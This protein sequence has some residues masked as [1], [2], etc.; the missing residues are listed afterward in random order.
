MSKKKRTRP[1]DQPIEGFADLEDEL[2]A[3]GTAA[4]EG[5]E[6]S[7]PASSA[8]ATAANQGPAV[9][10][11]RATAPRPASGR[12]ARSLPWGTLYTVSVIGA[13]LGLGGAALL[14]SGGSAGSAWRPG[15]LF[16]IGNYLAPASHPLNLVA[17]LSVVIGVIGVTGG[18]ALKAALRRLEQDRGTDA[19]V[20]A[21]LTAL[22]LD[23]EGP[24]GD[25][26]LRDH[27]A[28]GTFTAEVL[29]AWRLQGARL[30]RLNGVEGEIG[31]LQKALVENTRDVLTGRF[32]SPA[33]GAMADELVRF[34]DARNADAQELAELR[35]RNREDSE[36]I[37]KLIQDARA[38]N[39]AT[40][41][42]IGT[43]G[44]ALERMARR[45]EDLGAAL[46]HGE[47]AGGG[48]AA[49]LLAD[50]RHDLESRGS[51]APATA[52][53][54]LAARGSKL[55]FQI[56]MEVARL[57]P[58]GERLQ[59]MSQALEDLTTSL[60][61]AVDGSA[62]TGAPVDLAAVQGKL[63]AL[64]RQLTPAGGGALSPEALEELGRSGPV[65]GRVAANLADVAR[66]FQA[67][68][69]RLVELGRAFAGLTGTTFDAAVPPVGQ[70]EPVAENSLRVIPQDP[71]CR[72]TGGWNSVDPFSVD[73]PLVA[74]PSRPVLAP[75]A[76]AAPAPA[77]APVAAAPAAKIAPA[78][79]V[80]APAV[81]APSS[82]DNNDGDG[83]EIE[84]TPF[85]GALIPEDS[86]APVAPLELESILPERQAEPEPPVGRQLADP[87]D[88]IYDLSEFGA[89]RL[90]E[91]EAD[92][93]HELA[94]FGAVRVA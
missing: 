53:D 33:V 19:R 31:R 91:D 15:D 7:P 11:P 16:V 65:V 23:N 28:T 58:R 78:P 69:E 68:S 66:R 88:R 1:N 2:P 89:V 83:F 22:R 13:G 76:P 41:E 39:R 71:F 30:R 49:A 56:A 38:W 9:L 3:S 51:G 61:Q 94:E 12:A 54:D 72:D 25:A 57:G 6:A 74:P 26:A 37:V 85:G 79:V 84:R 81:A 63:D 36:T 4:R 35:T 86:E 70:G 45:L 90:E 52:L 18:R 64:S 60:R 27:P 62:G 55:A 43:Q 80:A 20:L 92:R 40:L 93:V 82:A 24:W 21:K 10:P 44:A 32:D 50:I 17:L 46:G 73:T 75:E 42:Q 5:A 48:Q 67:Q 47:Q 29:G 34:L 59:P 8:R 77:P 14:A 87:A